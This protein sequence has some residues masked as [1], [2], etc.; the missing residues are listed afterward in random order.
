V[1]RLFDGV[2]AGRP[3]WRANLLRYDA[4]DLHQPR[5]EDDP[6]PAGGPDAKYARSER[7]S[8]LRLPETGAVVFA[9]HTSVVALD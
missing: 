6:R 9:I 2:R 4:P 1:Q 3:M 5:T 8:V 7:Q